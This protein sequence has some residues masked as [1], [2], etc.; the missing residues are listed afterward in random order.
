MACYARNNRFNCVLV[1]VTGSVR[2]STTKRMIAL[3]LENLGIDVFESYGNWNNRIGV[4]LSLIG[5]DNRNA[6]IAVLEKG[7]SGKGEIL[8]L[9]RMAKPHIRVGL[10]VWCFTFGKSY[11]FGGGCDGKRRDF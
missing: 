3:T 10:N 6:D 4:V 2:K 1:G 8:E 9:V 7:M 5:I 11:K